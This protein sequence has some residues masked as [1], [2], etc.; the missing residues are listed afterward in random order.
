MLLFWRQPKYQS[1]IHQLM[2]VLAQDET[3]LRQKEQGVKNE[4]LKVP[5]E[6]VLELERHRLPHRTHPYFES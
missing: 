3:I 6:D 1:E 5:L 4:I 2:K